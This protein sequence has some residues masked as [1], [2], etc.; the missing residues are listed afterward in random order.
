MRGFSGWAFPRTYLHVHLTLITSLLMHHDI[1]RKFFSSFLKRTGLS[2]RL[3]LQR[4]NA[5]QRLI[6][7]LPITSTD[8]KWCNSLI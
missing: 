1:N 5:E 8:Y 3:L 4:K 6:Q 2:K 7:S